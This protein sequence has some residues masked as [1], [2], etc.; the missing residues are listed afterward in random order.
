VV[1]RKA[2]GTFRDPED[3]MVWQYLNQRLRVV[4]QSDLSP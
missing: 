4:T 2:D 1:H 3:E